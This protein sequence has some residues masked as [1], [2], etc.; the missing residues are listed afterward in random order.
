MYSSFINFFRLSR[1]PTKNKI[2]LAKLARALVV[3]LRKIIGKGS[4]TIVY[5]NGLFW[6][7]DLNEGIDLS[8]YLLGSFEPET[9]MAFNRIVRPGMTVVDIGANIGAH[10]LPLAEMVGSTGNIIAVEPTDWAF[11]KLLDNLSLNPHLIDRV[12][13]IQAMLVESDSE[14][15]PESIYSSWPLKSEAVDDFHPIHFGSLKSTKGATAITLDNLLKQLDITTVDVIK[16]DVDG[17]EIGVIKGAYNIIYYNKNIKII[18]E[19][20]PYLF[21]NET[22]EIGQFLSILENNGLIL[23]LLD[24]GASLPMTPHDIADLLP[25]GASINVLAHRN[26]DSRKF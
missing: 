4:K 8:I 25:H 10:T 7:L 9:N 23:Y 17:F 11:R 21:N 1:L 19:F 12:T 22:D 6:N 18:M 24:S 15:L 20:A 13:T 14:V 5:R 2:F 3:G 16:L 26:N